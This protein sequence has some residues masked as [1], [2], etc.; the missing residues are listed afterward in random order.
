M[1][2]KIIEADFSQGDEV[3]ATIEKEL[4]GMEIGVLVNNVGFSY[5]YPDYF[6][7]LENKDR[8]YKTIIQC[9]INTV[10]NMCQIV[11]PAMVE[12]RKGVVINL[13]S[14]SAL[15]PCPMLSVYGASKVP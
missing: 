5:P 11:M 10:I 3:F 12:Q 9:N 6:L 7:S 15:F 8:I 1:N 2:T 4:Y 14:A 13:S